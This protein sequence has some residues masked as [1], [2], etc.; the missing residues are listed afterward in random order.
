MDLK[1]V[2]KFLDKN[3]KINN[4]LLIEELERQGYEIF[5]SQGNDNN[6]VL[7]Y[8]DDDEIIFINDYYGYA[9]IIDKNNDKEEEE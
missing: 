3:R 2:N 4:I 6:S 8:E 1:N 9:D 7:F 5:Y